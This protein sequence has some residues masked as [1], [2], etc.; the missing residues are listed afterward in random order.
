MY[1]Y[2]RHLFLVTIILWTQSSM[3]QETS[4]LVRGNCG[5]CKERIESAAK[6]VIGV[7]SSIWDT[8]KQILIV[9][10]AP[11]FVEEELHQKMATI[12]HDTDQL[13]AR[14][15]RYTQL[16][17]CCKYREQYPPPSSLPTYP[18]VDTSSQTSSIKV[19]GNCGMCQSR[20]QDA[21]LT[22]YGIKSAHWDAETQMLT[23]THE[24]GLD[25][26]PTHQ[27]LAEAGH[28]TEVAKAT[29]EA[30]NDL[31]GC[32]KYREAAA[33]AQADLDFLPT[34]YIG[35]GHDHQSKLGGMIYEKTGEGKLLPLIGATVT[36][37]DGSDGTITDEDGFFE[38]PLNANT[39]AIVTS[40]IGYESDTITVEP[41]KLVAITMVSNLILDEV[42]ITH[43]RK[44][45]EV[46]FI[47][48]LKVQNISEKE[49]CKAAC[50]NLSESFETNPSVDVS[51]TDAVTGTHKIQML[52][53]AGPNIQITR[54]NMPYI[55]G[56]AGV[57]G[58][59]FTPGAWIEGMQLNMGT[60]SV[61]NGP[62]SITGQIN[63]ELRKP[64]SSELLYVNLFANMA[65]RLEANV[66]SSQKINDKWSSGLLLHGKYLQRELDNNHDKFLDQ[67]KNKSWIAVNRWNYRNGNLM[68]Q[69][70][71]K[72]T[73]LRTEAGQINK[74]LDVPPSRS[75]M[76]TDRGEIWAKIGKVFE[77]KP[78][79]SIGLQVSGM[80][81]DQKSLFN[82]ESRFKRRYDAQ[83]KS[84][85]TNLIYQSII[86]TTD[87]IIKT[88]IS[89]QMDD[90]KEVVTQTYDGQRFEHLPGVFGEY[91]YVGSERVA[92]VAGLRVD[93][94]NIYGTFVTP[95]LHVKYSPSDQTAL[96][97]GVGRGQRTA[98]VFA[99]QIGVFASN[100][101]IVFDQNYSYGSRPEVA[102]NIGTSFTQEFTLGGRSTVWGIEYYY[103][104]FDQQTV[105]DW[106][107]SPQALV[108]GRLNGK[109][110]SHSIQTQIDMEVVKGVDLRLAYRYNDPRM[111]HTDG[112]LRRV[113]LVSDHR[114][115]A[116]VGWE[117]GKGWVWDG[118][119]NWQGPKRLPDTSSNPAEFQRQGESP[120]YTVT[121]MQISKQFGKTW[122]FYFGGENIFNYTQDDPI[123][124][125]SDVDSPYFDASMVW[126]PIFGGNYY[127][128]MRYKLF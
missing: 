93:R 125:V 119:I 46:S 61:V 120:S 4:I 118:T 89:Y 54:E 81:H 95:R 124:S 68:G 40:Y 43:R 82:S 55:R 126:G 12:G 24:A 85:Y 91:Q 45:T 35:D 22:Q 2:I 110:R 51:T 8:E 19:L 56:L 33:Q 47:N 50:C 28:D 11:F 70:G 111:T 41:G 122:D 76:N 62:E 88:G 67:P 108:L 116:N 36:W 114:A 63:V 52:G 99:E 29:L 5:M 96:R 49:L 20:I 7:S 44:S 15:D 3:A 73:F 23:L 83:Q 30:Y 97:L 14:Q 127:I 1:I 58:L 65:G 16:H 103:T 84:L 38:L 32:C 59:E 74:G 117:L 92:L 128:G 48:P 34:H 60:G 113:A 90:T 100:R 75:T 27:A 26:G 17:G 79:A 87:H 77:D 64:H 53:L 69:I 78:Y 71:V 104:Q 13:L 80:V 123:L 42:Q 18:P 6:D 39:N 109:S 31:H 101:A 105:V 94:H 121:N 21:A 57:I 102:W 98:F 66:T 107:V 106:D 115:F 112:E 86:G 9:Q 10:H 37:L 72:G 25:L